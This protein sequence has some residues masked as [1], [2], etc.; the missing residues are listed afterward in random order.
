MFQ[1]GKSRFTDTGF[2]DT[3]FADTGFTDTCFA[4]ASLTRRG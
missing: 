4:D 1:K 2:A 3:C